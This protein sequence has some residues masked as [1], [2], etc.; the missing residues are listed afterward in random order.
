MKTFKHSDGWFYTTPIYTGST[1]DIERA[2]VCDHTWHSIKM[3]ESFISDDEPIPE[4]YNRVPSGLYLVIIEQCH[5]CNA[6]I[7]SRY[8]P[9]ENL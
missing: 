2:K 6:A 4:G 3:S 8:K 1:S 5:R 9:K 7:R